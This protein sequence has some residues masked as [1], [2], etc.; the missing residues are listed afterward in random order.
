M[1][2]W[3]R[4]AGQQAGLLRELELRQIQVTRESLLYVEFSFLISTMGD[5]VPTSR[6]PCKSGT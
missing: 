2:G 3:L 1:K 5:V 4:P 6:G